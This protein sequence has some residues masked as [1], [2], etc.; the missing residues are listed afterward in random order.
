ML[1]APDAAKISRHL[2]LLFEGSS[3]GIQDSSLRLSTEMGDKMMKQL[4]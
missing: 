3:H 4:H 2:F 1:E